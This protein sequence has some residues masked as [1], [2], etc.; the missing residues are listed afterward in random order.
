MN[1]YIKTAII[2]RKNSKNWVRKHW[3]ILLLSTFDKGHVVKKPHYSCHQ[4]AV[5]A[6]HKYNFKEVHLFKCLPYFNKYQ[7][8]CFLKNP[9]M[10][11]KPQSFMLFSTLHWGKCP[12]GAHDFPEQFHLCFKKK[13]FKLSKTSV[14]FSTE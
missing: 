1:V 12:N 13:K 7:M 6:W 2:P 9:I 14:A 5:S 10:H 4:M 11:S 8:L 3:L